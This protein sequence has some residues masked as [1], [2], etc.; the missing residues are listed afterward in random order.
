MWIRRQKS[1]KI[2][3][4]NAE[5]LNLGLIFSKFINKKSDITRVN[6]IHNDKVQY[7]KNSKNIQQCQ[8]GHIIQSSKL[9]EISNG[10]RNRLAKQRKCKYAIVKMIIF[11]NLS[12]L[13]LLWD[14]LFN[15]RNVFYDLGKPNHNL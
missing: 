15:S 3:T 1:P 2:C 4:I 10:K 7:L 8:N 13:S 14:H 9:N 5:K 11:L 6:I 12:G